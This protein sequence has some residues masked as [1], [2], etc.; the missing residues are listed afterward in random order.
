MIVTIERRNISR[1]IRKSHKVCPL[2]LSINPLLKKGVHCTCDGAFLFVHYK[3]Q[4]ESDI[5]PLPPN[6]I[7]W[8]FAYDNG[9]RVEPITATIDVP[10]DAIFIRVHKPNVRREPSLT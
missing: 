3:W 8:L 10:A 5:V 2:V 9:K 6:I 4:Y 1:G 7:D